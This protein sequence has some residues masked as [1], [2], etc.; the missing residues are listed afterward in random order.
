MTKAPILVAA[1]AIVDE[2]NRVLVTQRAKNSHQGG[3][4]EFPGGKCKKG[5]TIKEALDRE[6]MEELGI[7][8]I[9]PAH[10]ITLTHAY[11]EKTVTLSVWKVRSYSGI[12][13]ARESQPLLWQAVSE[14]DPDL[15]PA[16]D[17]GIIRALQL[18][19]TCVITPDIQNR[20]EEQYLREMHQV[21]DRGAKLILFRDHHLDRLTYRQLAVEIIELCDRY[22]ATCMLNTPI[23]W[24][25]DFKKKNIH[26]SAFRLMQCEK[27]P[28][29]NK[30]FLSAACHDL[31]EIRQAEK[32]GADFILLSPVKK[33]SSHPD[34][35]GM[36]WEKFS[37]LVQNCS[38]PVYALG[39][40]NKTDIDVAQSHGAQGVAGITGFWSAQQVDD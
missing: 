23:D 36:G 2:Q 10:L 35:E 18:P 4:W 32:I 28:N 17:H 7:N 33:T 21:L 11:P 26:M 13:H 8:P 9:E 27:R 30:F 12:P 38:V 39:G 29:S 40:M 31:N 19:D 20:S 5:E 1:A 22:N 6:L 37:D 15:F 24:L 16:A 3:K 25:A 34:T 14:L